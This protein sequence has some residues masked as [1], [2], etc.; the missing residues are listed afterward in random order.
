MPRSLH[1]CFDEI[2]PILE[3]LSGSRENE[4]C[5]LGGELHARLHYGRIEVI[6]KQGL[7]EFLVDFIECN[8]ALC[9]EI[10]HAFL[11]SSTWN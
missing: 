4:S 1:A 6:L 9:S 7:H 2:M 8:E 11:S 10:Q 3:D 5:R